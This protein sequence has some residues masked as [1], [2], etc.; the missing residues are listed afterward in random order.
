MGKSPVRLISKKKVGPICIAIEFTLRSHFL[1]EEKVTDSRQTHALKRAWKGYAVTRT[2]P[3]LAR[4]HHGVQLTTGYVDGNFEEVIG[5]LIPKGADKN[6]SRLIP[7]KPKRIKKEMG[8]TSLLP[9]HQ[10]CEF[11]PASSRTNIL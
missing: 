6:R 10:S 3:R 11:T 9:H 7:S 5:R 8:A 2:M 4:H 1:P